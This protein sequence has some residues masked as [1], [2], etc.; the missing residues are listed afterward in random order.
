MEI[1]RRQPG[2]CIVGA[3]WLPGQKY[4]PANRSSGRNYTKTQFPNPQKALCAF[5]FTFASLS[6]RFFYVCNYC[7]CNVCNL[8]SIPNDLAT[9]RQQLVRRFL[10]LACALMPRTQSNVWPPT[11]WA[12]LGNTPAAAR[13][14]HHRCWQG[15]NLHQQTVCWGEN[16]P[17]HN[18]Q[19]QKKRCVR[20]LYVCNFSATLV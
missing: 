16:A 11:Y 2:S 14:S 10:G 15:W 20:F 13:K 1:R 7:F 17:R 9:L 12:R 3:G 8:N 4:S 18:L 19:T 6:Q 5:W